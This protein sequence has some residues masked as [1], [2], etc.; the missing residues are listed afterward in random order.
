MNEDKWFSAKLA[1]IPISVMIVFI[2]LLWALTSGVVGTT[3]VEDIHIYDKSYA[4]GS[5]NGIVV[6]GDTVYKVPDSN[7]YAHLKA[8]GNY[9]VRVVCPI[10]ASP[11]ISE[12]V[13]CS[14]ECDV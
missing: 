3:Y 14:S 11:L 8:G 7:V 12:I 10:A 6:T 9:T 4:S 1:L 2:V 13:R 5:S